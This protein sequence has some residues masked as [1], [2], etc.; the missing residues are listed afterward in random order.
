MVRI[1]RDDIIIQLMD[2]AEMGLLYMIVG[3]KQ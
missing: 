3:A 2:A 1:G